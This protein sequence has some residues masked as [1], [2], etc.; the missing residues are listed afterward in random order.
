MFHA[1]D[2]VTSV[3]VS[4]TEEGAA[5]S[6]RLAAAWARENLAALD[7]GEPEVTGGETFLALAED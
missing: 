4:A 6:V 1:R 2:R 7:V 3:T 5:G